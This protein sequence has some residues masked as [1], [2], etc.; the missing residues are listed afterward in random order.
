MRCDSARVETSSYRARGC[1]SRQEAGF[2]QA[3]CQGSSNVGDS[4]GGGWVRVIWG[5]IG[6]WA[7]VSPFLER[8]IREGGE[9]KVHSFL[10]ARG[11]VISD[12]RQLIHSEYEVLHT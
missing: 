2:L 8:E 10:D 5:W 12:L 1:R 11:G 4:K 3:S 9:R 7:R 6:H